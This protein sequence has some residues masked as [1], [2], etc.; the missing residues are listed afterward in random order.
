MY[1]GFQACANPSQLRHHTEATFPVRPH[2]Q[3][4]RA[5]GRELN[6]LSPPRR[7]CRNRTCSPSPPATHA[8]NTPMAGGRL[9]RRDNQQTLVRMAGFEPAAPCIQSTCATKLRYT[10]L[11]GAPVPFGP[12]TPRGPRGNRTL[13]LIRVIDALHQASCWTNGQD[14]GI[15]THILLNPNQA[16]LRFLFTLVWSRD[17]RMNGSDSKSVLPY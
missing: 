2:L 10:L 5:Q 16:R 13:C 9:F 1:Q 12:V 17:V 4:F 3:P 7:P 14:G 8:S 15:R 11:L 6:P